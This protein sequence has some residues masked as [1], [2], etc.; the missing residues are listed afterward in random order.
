MSGIK[1]TNQ[2]NCGKRG[3]SKL[4]FWFEVIIDFNN[5]MIITIIIIYITKK[6]Q[7]CKLPGMV[8]I[9]RAKTRVIG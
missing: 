8:Y 1:S 2:H 6:V 7:I 9:T 4:G 3:N 5:F